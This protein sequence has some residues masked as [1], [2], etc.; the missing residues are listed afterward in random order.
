[1]ETFI[2]PINFKSL[3]LFTP[4]VFALLGCTE[5]LYSNTTSTTKIGE[6]KH[7]VRQF[8]KSYDN[9]QAEQISLM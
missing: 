8:E 7:E 2:Q 9:Q 6:F 4:L 5:T 3:F 1:M